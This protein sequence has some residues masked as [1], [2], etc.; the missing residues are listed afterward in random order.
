[1]SLAIDCTRVVNPANVEAQL[2]G[3]IVHGINAA[4][5]GRQTFV[6]GVA[7]RRNFNT[8]RMI[9]IGDDAGGRGYHGAAH[10]RRRPQRP[11]RRCR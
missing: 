9:R 2:T 6:A 3:G 5:Y 7:Q 10:R 8:N 11:D 4:L 1:M